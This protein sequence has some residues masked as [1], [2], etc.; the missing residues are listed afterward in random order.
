MAHVYVSSENAHM[1]KSRSDWLVPAGLIVLSLVPAIAG[2]ARVAGLAAEATITPENARFVAAPLPVVLH[3]L[4]AIPYSVFGALQFSN[5]LRRR[6]ARWHR[7]SG[8]ALVP[9]AVLVALSGLWM[10]LTY[11][12]PAGDGTAVYFERLVFG[13]AMLVSVMIGVHAIRQRDFRAHGDWMTRAYAIALGAGTQVLTHI[14][15]ML[16]ATGKP[17]ETARGVMMGAGWVINVIVAEWAIRRTR[18]RVNRTARRLER[19]QLP[20]RGAR[21]LQSRGFGLREDDVQ[22]V[23]ATGAAG[24]I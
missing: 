15:W 14:P 11:P 23:P 19:E 13:V 1:R 18:N 2:T 22:V 16:F 3:V 5:A 4:S 10:T 9:C 20:H 24:S 21:P 17:G 8:R 6:G 7:I 12:W